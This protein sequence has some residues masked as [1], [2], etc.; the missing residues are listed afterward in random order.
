MSNTITSSPKQRDNTGAI[1][2]QQYIPRCAGVITVTDSIADELKRRHQLQVKPTVL[3]NTC[4]Y[5]EK[6]VER[7]K[8][9]RLYDI[10]TDRK[11]VLCQGGLVSGRSLDEFIQAWHH[12]P[13]P[14]PALVFLGFGQQSYVDKL[15]KMITRLKLDDDVYIGKAVAPDEILAYTQDADLGLISN[16]GAGLNNT[17]GGPN[18]LF[19]YIQARLP[20][21]SFEHNGV[22]KNTRTNGY[23]LDDKMAVAQ[24]SSGRDRTDSI[25][26]RHYRS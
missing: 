17:D 11:I 10:P 5:L 1:I 2:A 20:V 25:Q 9:R 18:R 13:P 7:N 14:R 21:L 26:Y 6:K 23:R 8:L 12:L 4:P 3:F 16:R 24:A 22:R 15:R 19:E